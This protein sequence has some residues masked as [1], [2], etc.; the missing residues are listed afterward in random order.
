MEKKLSDYL[1]L[2]L[3]CEVSVQG[4][5]RKG[6]LTGVT[7]GGVECEIQYQLV[8]NPHHLEEEPEFS[9]IE[10][11]KPAL[12]PLS[13]MTEEE[14]YEVVGIMLGKKV[15]FLVIEITDDKEFIIARYKDEKS[16]LPGYDRIQMELHI[17]NIGNAFRVDNC[18]NY[19]KNGNTGVTH[20]ILHNSHEITRYLLSKHFDLFGL[21][22]SG[23]A[24]N[25][26]STN[27]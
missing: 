17:S 2:Y 4:E 19:I 26:E 7:N 27:H 20:E 16:E 11:V 12:R 1:H 6:Y 13:S 8:D 24:I 10:D 3:G 21:I 25:S 22:E 15:E 14:I 9:P 23:L 18:W 5:E